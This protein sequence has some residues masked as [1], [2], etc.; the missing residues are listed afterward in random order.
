MLKFL[1]IPLTFTTR[2]TAYG[3]GIAGAAGIS[4]ILAVSFGIYY[5]RAINF[6]L[7]DTLM[8]IIYVGSAVAAVG[9]SVQF[10]ALY[11]AGFLGFTRPVRAIN[12]F[13][14]A[15][16]NL[17]IRSD[18][19]D[20][21]LTELLRALG[22]IP[23]INALTP[24][25][26]VQVVF[27][28]VIIGAQFTGSLTFQNYIS[29]GIINLMISFVHGGYCVVIGE[30]LTG[31]MRAECKRKMFER[32]IPFI[33]QAVTTVRLKLGFFTVFFAF[34]VYVAVTLVYYNRDNIQGILLFT[35]LAMASAMLMAYMIFTLIYTS[36]KDIVAAMDDLKSGGSGLVFSKSTDAEFVKVAAGISEAARTIKDYQANLEHKITER[37]SE[38][39]DSLRHVSA[40]KNQ[41]D[42]DYFLTALL[43]K[44]LIGNY[45]KNKFV[46]VDMLL[47]QKKQFDFKAKANEIGGDICIAHSISLRGRPYTLFLNGDAMGKSMQGAGGALVL[48]AVVQSIVERTKVSPKEQTLFPERWLKAIF[49][50]LQKTFES[51]NGSMLVSVVMGLVDEENGFVYLLN[52][53][54]P[55]SVLY[56]NAEARFIE[57]SLMLRKLGTLGVNMG[58]QVL[59]LQMEP[60]DTLIVGSDGRDDLLLGKNSDG[61]RIINEDEN[62]FLKHVTTAGGDLPA[63]HKAC[64][65]GGEITDDF[66]LLSLTYL[67]DALSQQVSEDIR[68]QIQ[69]SRK[70]IAAKQYTEAIVELEQAYERST[71]MTAQPLAQAL[72]QITIKTGDTEKALKYLAVY[73]D[74]NPADEKTIF[75]YGQLCIKEQ[76]LDLAYDIFNRLRTRNPKDGRVASQIAKIDALMANTAQ[77]AVQK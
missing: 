38:L 72:A 33:D 53:E 17:Q 68:N 55:W 27:A 24:V 16:P 52:A 21:E 34:V 6:P 69:R 26:A 76:L 61:T 15:A 75:S 18:V 57:N 12:R 70:L 9:H 14:I 67:P 2:Y 23:I 48:G 42:G 3:V 47:H 71:V 7:N 29:L 46:K 59:T 60:G 32:G 44:P 13:I 58:I 65:D 31:D 62:L 25:I 20:E 4:A 77:P 11:K 40:L 28:A 41:Q 39:A 63:I 56:R 35:I 5:A 37:T 45:C 22:L 73:T 43:L 30:L 50:E 10:G 54:H 74:L 19:K 36:L 8:M 1:N 64:A 49:I 66:S 51:F